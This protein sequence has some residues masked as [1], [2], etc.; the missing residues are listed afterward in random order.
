MTGEFLIGLAFAGGIGAETIHT[1]RKF[2]ACVLLEQVEA[3]SAT[4]TNGQARQGPRGRHGQPS[5]GRLPG[6]LFV[7][8]GCRGK[9]MSLNRLIYYSAMVGGWAAFVG[10]LLAE[11][12]VVRRYGG[13]AEVAVIGALVGAA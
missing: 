4:W 3:A 6:G 9:R 1:L 8:P 2:E 12:L 7:G 11:I 5:R 13:R 10:W